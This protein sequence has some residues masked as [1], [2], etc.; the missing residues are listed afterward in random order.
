[1]LYLFLRYDG[2]W[3]SELRRIQI[4]ISSNVSPFMISSSNMISYILLD[5]K[6]RRNVKDKGITD[7][8]LHNKLQ[9]CMKYTG[10]SRSWISSEA[11]NYQIFTV[12]RI[13]SDIRE[14]FCKIYFIVLNILVEWK[15]DFW[16][17]Y[18]FWKVPIDIYSLKINW[19]DIS[20]Y[21]PLKL[22]LHV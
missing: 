4:Y 8:F 18:S 21:R 5:I 16:E 12:L 9:F 19:K 15:F 13:V 17:R 10:K 22:C 14:I 2:A 20:Y 11:N 6:R 7:S 3:K 1:M